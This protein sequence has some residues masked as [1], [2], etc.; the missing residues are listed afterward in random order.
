M[1]TEI[2]PRRLPD[3]ATSPQSPW[4]DQQ[5]WVAETC[6]VRI[7]GTATLRKKRSC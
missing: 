3:L 2:A 7:L 4:H 5:L 6:G 1:L